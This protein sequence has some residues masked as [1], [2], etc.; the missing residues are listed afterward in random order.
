MRVTN[1]TFKDFL[2]NFRFQKKIKCFLLYPVNLK[3][4]SSELWVTEMWT[5]FYSWKNLI[6]FSEWKS[7]PLLFCGVNFDFDF[8]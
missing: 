3:K 2:V 8:F 1:W 7:E 4:L 6:F 5:F